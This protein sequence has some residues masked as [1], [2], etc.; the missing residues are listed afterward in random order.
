ML[1]VRRSTQHPKNVWVEKMLPGATVKMLW[2]VPE[3]EKC[4][5]L[6]AWH[7]W[8]QELFVIRTPD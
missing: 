4:K 7:G 8:N 6:V 1:K 5:H 2:L 3:N